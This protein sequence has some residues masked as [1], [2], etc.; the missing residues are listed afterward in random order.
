MKDCMYERVLSRTKK[1]DLLSVLSVIWTHCTLSLQICRLL[2]KIITHGNDLKIHLF[3]FE[4][5]CGL[6]CLLGSETSCW[7]VN[8][9][10]LIIRL[11]C[12]IP[13]L[14]LFSPASCCCQSVSVW[15]GVVCLFCPHLSVASWS[16]KN[17]AN[18]IFS[19]KWGQHQACLNCRTNAEML[20]E[21][22]WSGTVS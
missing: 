9:L 4:I 5:S 10:K 22:W 3:G 1:T 13:P 16:P 19:H 6:K 2:W 20:V 14:H 11:S 18:I 8:N 7:I 21:M 15:Q 12:R 17:P